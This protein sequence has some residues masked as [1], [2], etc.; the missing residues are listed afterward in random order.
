MVL[1][2]IDPEVV[3]VARDRRF[4]YKTL[5]SAT[6]MI[7]V[8]YLAR[9]NPDRVSPTCRRTI[10][11]LKIRDHCLGTLLA[12]V[13]VGGSISSAW[14]G[15]AHLVA[16]ARSGAILEAANADAPNRPASLAKMM[17]LYLTFEAIRSG[18]LAW[19]DLFP[20]SR[21]AAS[22]PTYKLGVAVGGTISTEEAVLGM[23]V[24]SANDAAV[25]VAERLGGSEAGFAAAMTTKAQQ[26]G[27]PSTTFRNATGLTAEGQ[28]T[29]AR[30]MAVL[31]L[32]L[33]RD[34]PREYQLFSTQSFSFR[35]QVLSGHNELLDDYP[36]VDGIKT[37]YTS[38]SGYNIVT[39]VGMGRRRLIGVVMGDPTAE[40]R[41]KR[42]TDL[43]N[44]ALVE[45]GQ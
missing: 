21:N 14:A 16:D 15:Q 32:A 39:S 11:M 33:M 2:R 30:D 45:P 24:L 9:R 41:D 13:M 23:I 36:G 5:A 43:L 42:M 12:I 31:G 7:S 40:A 1:G 17:T 6:R 20:V 25:A 44:R 27:M 19:D 4:S 18:I 38:A 34:F 22:K 26:L 3:L 37:G 10:P 28:M 8:R 29:T 35:G